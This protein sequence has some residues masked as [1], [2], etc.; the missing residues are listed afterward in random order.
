MTCG[1]VS[2]ASNST[3]PAVPS[4]VGNHRDNEINITMRY[5]SGNQFPLALPANATTWDLYRAAESKVDS[6]IAI[7]LP[8]SPNNEII[9]NFEYDQSLVALGIVNG[10]TLNFI[11][12]PD[13][14]VYGQCTVAS[15][16]QVMEQVGERR[17]LDNTEEPIIGPPEIYQ[18]SSDG[19]NWHNLEEGH[20]NMIFRDMTFRGQSPCVLGTTAFVCDGGKKEYIRHLFLRSFNPMGTKKKAYLTQHFGLLEEFKCVFADQ[21]FVY[22]NNMPSHIYRINGTKDLWGTL[23]NATDRD[24]GRINLSPADNQM[25]KSLLGSIVSDDLRPDTVLLSCHDDDGK[26]DGFLDT[27]R[28]IPPEE[29]DWLRLDFKDR[30]QKNFARLYVKKNVGRAPDELPSCFVTLRMRD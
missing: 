17:L 26:F 30:M 29:S 4:T 21:D 7:F 10:A 6:G 3:D 15:V 8:N 18:Y 1:N 23:Y 12:T 16:I 27:I 9:P 5:M 28:I 2:S 24:T 25:L 20:M 13:C 19:E 11:T 22:D 14:K